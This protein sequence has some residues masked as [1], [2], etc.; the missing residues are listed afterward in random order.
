MIRGG[1][2]TLRYVRSWKRGS[3]PALREIEI[4]RAGSAIAAT[5]ATPPSPRGKLPG[6]IVLGGVTRMGRFHPQLAR[7]AHALALSGGAVIVPEIPEWR[8]L[9]L[10]PGV[11]EPTVEAAV[12]ALDERPEVDHGRYGVVG[13]SFGAPQAVMSANHPE[14]RDRIGVVLTFGGYCNLE[15]T[16][17]CQLTGLHEWRGVTH[18]VEP[19]PYGRWVIASNYLAGVP[20]CESTLG[21]GSALRRLALASTEGRVPA[22]DARLDPLKE[23]LRAGVS[24]GNREL[25][26]L[27]APP[28]ARPVASSDRSEAMA[29]DLA[30]ACRRAEP[31]LD[32]LPG[33]ER[34]RVPVHLF[35]GRGDRLVPFTESLRFHAALPDTLAANVT[36]TGLFAHSADN[37]PPRLTSRLQEGWIFFRG[38]QRALGTMC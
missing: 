32:P 9:R 34:I 7:F 1:P 12:R 10:D 16:L 29:I 22:W 35:H 8:D 33:L 3:A 13:F 21:V 38:L 36:V 2:Q 11:T 20:G 4:D 37:R 5:L 30:A 27:F 19:D 23:E 17:R 24:A 28:T 14:I 6:W 15:R 31:L 18:R 25:F 26:D